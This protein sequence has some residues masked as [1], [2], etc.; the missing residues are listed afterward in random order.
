M[1][2]HK[3]HTTDVLPESMTRGPQVWEAR[4]TDDHRKCQHCGIVCPGKY[5]DEIDSDLKLCRDI[6]KCH[7]RLKKWEN[8]MISLIKGIGVKTCKN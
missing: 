8:I 1:R 2:I 5:M 3:E 6:E 7:S 4:R